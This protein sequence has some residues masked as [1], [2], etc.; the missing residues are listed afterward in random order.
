MFTVFVSVLSDQHE[1]GPAVDRGPAP[2][3]CVS[4]GN[5]PEVERDVDGRPVEGDVDIIPTYCR[6]CRCTSVD[7]VHVVGLREDVD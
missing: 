7:E 2:V 1:L 5:L 4:T 6:S 3:A